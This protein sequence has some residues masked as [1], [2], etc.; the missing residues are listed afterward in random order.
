MQTLEIAP[1]LHPNRVYRLDQ[2]SVPD[3]ARGD[4][5]AAM[6]R[7]LGH[8]ATLPGFLGHVAFTKVGGPTKFHY[9]TLAMWEDAATFER[10]KEAMQ[11]FMAQIGFDAAAKLAE[12]GVEAELGA[13]TA[14]A[15]IA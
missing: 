9:A 14:A 6:R 13:Y 3:G 10:A 4:F 7:N 1:N 2:F 11:A 15:G 8:L 12:W 5:E